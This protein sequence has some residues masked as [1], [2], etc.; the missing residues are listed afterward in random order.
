MELEGVYGGVAPPYQPLKALLWAYPWLILGFCHEDVGLCV[1]PFIEAGYPPLHS[2]GTRQR[3]PC[4][5]KFISQSGSTL[6]DRRPFF[7]FWFPCFS[8]HLEKLPYVLFNEV[9]TPSPG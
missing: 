6:V 7:P 5:G 3:V 4:K 8:H 2:L 9:G 1:Y